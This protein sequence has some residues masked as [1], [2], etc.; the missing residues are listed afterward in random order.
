M[1]I[2]HDHYL[3]YEIPEN[4]TVEESCDSTIIYDKGGDGALILSFYTI[5]DMRKT[6]EEHL[7][8]MVK[9]FVDENNI[10][11]HKAFIFDNTQKDKTVLYGSGNTVDHWFIKLWLIAKEQ[12]IIF[13]TY[14]SET[15][16]AELE[17]IEKIVS[18][19]QFIN[20]SL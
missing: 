18:S 12:K 8:F 16:T 7:C 1:L 10:L 6:L 2:Q 4:W 11:L 5:S 14:Q 15:Q 3:T 13:A 17:C 9:R 20:R 19:F